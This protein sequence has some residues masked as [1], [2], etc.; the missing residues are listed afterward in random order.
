MI[1]LLKRIFVW[2]VDVFLPLQ[3]II[4][5]ESCP[6]LSD[7]AKPVFD[8]LIRRGLNQKYKLIW[9]CFECSTLSYPKIKN[10]IYFN[11]KQHRFKNFLLNH[12][13]SL[14]I[15]C[16]RFVGSNRKGQTTIYLCHGSPL[17]DASS[18]Y[19][20]PNYVNYVI[21]TSEFLK[22]ILAD[23]LKVNPSII[24]TLGFPRTDILFDRP[25]KLSLIFGEYRRFVVWYP[26]VKKFKGGQKTGSVKPI[27]FLWN[28]EESNKIN[29][30]AKENS[31]LIIVKPHFAQLTDDI[32]HYSFSNILF[33]D[34]E[35]FSNHQFTSY[36]L[37]GSSDALLTDYSSIYS[38][39][40][41][42]NKPIG[43]IWEDIEEYSKNPGLVKEYDF[44]CSGGE[45]LF[46]SNDL[47]AFLD[48]I[49]NGVDLYASERKKVLP[50]IHSFSDGKST[51]RVVEKV[52]E[53]VNDH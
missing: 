26:T 43:L 32:K 17:K 33:I 39:Y 4:L 47:C 6:D 9:M 52:L 34:D 30:A 14:T 45:K 48:R 50:Y 19:N 27:Q 11:V 24:L 23:Q 35:F 20:A 44:I 15:C 29:A 3:K 10:V 53:L 2:L 12:R 46:N 8:E 51:K 40:L 28:E 18:Y 42:C 22:P 7:N 13:A 21:G 16:N 25:K 31:I 5:F 41:L 38:D 49:G 36:E 1:K 37:I